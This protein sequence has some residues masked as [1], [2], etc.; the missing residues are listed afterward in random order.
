MHYLMLKT[1]NVSGIKYL[2]KT[3]RFNPY[4]YSGSGKIWKRHLKKY[5]WDFTTEILAECKTKDELVQKGLYYSDLW[6][7]VNSAEFANL[8]P[9][10]GDGGATTTG[11]KMSKACSINKSKSLRKFYKYATEEYRA[12][13]KKLNSKC[14]EMRTYVTPKGVYTN[15]FIAATANNCSNV[16]IIN[17]CVK[18]TNKP[19]ESKKYW[20]YGWRGKTWK[21]LGWYN[22]SLNS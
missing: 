21:E 18:D 12:W 17:R 3:S 22:L 5:G 6:D 16:T 2:C 13:R 1:H 20:K 8:V 10:S 7:V 19:I 9:E 14:H 15:A 4:T 11:K